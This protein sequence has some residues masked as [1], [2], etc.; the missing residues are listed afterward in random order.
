ME[1][2]D[3]FEVGIDPDWGAPQTL[4]GIE[5]GLLFAIGPLLRVLQG[6]ILS[7]RILSICCGLCSGRGKSQADSAG[8]Q[9]LEDLGGQ[10]TRQLHYRL[11]VT[12]S[13]PK[14]AL[15]VMTELHHV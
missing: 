5:F 12:T 11:T 15:Q 1:L 14:R 3:E 8:E 10:S 4:S 9:W 7:G 2:V 13:R 6:L